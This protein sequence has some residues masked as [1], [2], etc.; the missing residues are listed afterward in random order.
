VGEGEE[1]ESDPEIEK[2]MCV[3]G[4]AVAA[5]IDGQRP[6][7]EREPVMRV[8]FRR[9]AVK[10]HRSKDTALLAYD[11]LLKSFRRTRGVSRCRTRRII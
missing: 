9:D 7:G 3:E 1:G 6:H 2:K 4:G 5:G 10:E 8:K 11:G